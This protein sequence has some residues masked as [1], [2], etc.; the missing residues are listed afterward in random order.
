ML[1]LHPHD[2]SGADT[3][4]AKPCASAL[5]AVREACPGIPISLS[6]SETIE[7][8]SGRLDIIARWTEMPNLF[9]LS[10]LP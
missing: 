1:H 4:A 6:N 2:E 10:V 3:V 5:R 8:H 9:A 7:A